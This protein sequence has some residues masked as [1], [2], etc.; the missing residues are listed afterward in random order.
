MAKRTANFEKADSRNLPLVDNVMILEFMTNSSNHNIAEIRGAKALMSSGIVTCPQLWDMW[1][2]REAWESVLSKPELYQSIEHKSGCKHSL[3]LL[4]WLEKQSC[5]P[6][7]TSTQCFW[8]KP[9]LGSER[10][11]HVL[12]EDVNAPK[13][14][15]EKLD[16]VKDA[17]C[18]GQHR[19]IRLCGSKCIYRHG[20]LF[21]SM[22]SCAKRT[23]RGTLHLLH[24][25]LRMG[26][27]CVRLAARAASYSSRHESGQRSHIQLV[28]GTHGTTGGVRHVPG[29]TQ[30]AEQQHDVHIAHWTIFPSPFS[31]FT[32][33]TVFRATAYAPA[34]QAF[35]TVLPLAMHTASLPLI[36]HE[37]THST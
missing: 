27:W 24:A 7:C 23:L 4:F 1:K 13:T 26:I 11:K 37:V 28:G 34:K 22:I 17:R 19:R 25:Q 3:L 36:I 5:E 8:I 16:N 2:C 9:T 29:C 30:Q 6:S 12:A 14:L 18:G 33:L 10:T 31:P 15:R 21:L 32:T 20:S 35:S